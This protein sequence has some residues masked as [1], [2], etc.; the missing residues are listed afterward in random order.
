MALGLAAPTLWFLLFGFG[1]LTDRWR[2]VLI[3]LWPTSLMLMLTTG[4]EETL[5]AYAIAAVAIMGNVVLYCLIGIVAW[6]VRR[7]LLSN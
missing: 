4:R 5:E 2:D 7:F 3:R 1:A 6:A